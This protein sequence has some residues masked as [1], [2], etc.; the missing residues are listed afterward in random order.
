MGRGNV[1]AGGRDLCLVQRRNNL[2]DN[3]V[4]RDP[5]PGGTIPPMRK[6]DDRRRIDPCG[7]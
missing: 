1:R 5:Q 2:G 4:G 7:R 3:I 6:R